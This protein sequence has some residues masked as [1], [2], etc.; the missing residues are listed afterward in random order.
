[1]IFVT[2]TSDRPY[3]ATTF[4]NWFHD[5]CIAA[6]LKECSSH[7]LRKAG[8][9]RLA[10]AGATE[11]EIMAFLGHK[12]PVEARTYTKKANRKHLADTGM[13]KL[14]RAKRERDMSNLVERLDKYRSK[15][16]KGKVN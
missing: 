6:G 15:T 14:V 16:L 3:K 10:N 9:T 5:Q 8:A 1:M 7:G 11:F 2:H 13:E 12:T 4:G